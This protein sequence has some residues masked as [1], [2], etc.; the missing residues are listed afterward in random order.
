MSVSQGQLYIATASSNFY[1]EGLGNDKSVSPVGKYQLMPRSDF[2]W[3]DDEN[4][5]PYLYYIRKPSTNTTVFD[6]DH[7]AIARNQNNQNFYFYYSG[8]KIGDHSNPTEL[9]ANAVGDAIYSDIYLPT[10]WD[11]YNSEEK[12]NLLI[13]DSLYQQWVFTNGIAN[14]EY[15]IT[16]GVDVVYLDDMPEFRDNTDKSNGWEIQ[17]DDTDG[18]FQYYLSNELV[19]DLDDTTTRTSESNYIRISKERNESIFD[20]DYSQEVFVFIKKIEGAQAEEGAYSHREYDIKEFETD[21][22]QESPPVIP[23]SATR[24]PTT[25]PTVTPTISIT[26]TITE[27]PTVTPSITSTVSI[28][29]SPNA[30]PDPTK[31]PTATPSKTNSPTPSV[32]LTPAPPNT[33]I[34]KVFNVISLGS[35][36]KPPAS[37]TPTSTV[38]A[39]VTK[40]PTA[41]PT[42]TPTVTDTQTPTPTVTQTSTISV[43]PIP[44]TTP[45]ITPTITATPSPTP[46][47]P[48]ILGWNQ[49]FEIKS[50]DNDLA[51][52]EVSINESGN[53]FAV[54]YPQASGN[55]GFV[56]VHGKSET[57]IYLTGGYITGDVGP[58][59]FGTSVN[60]SA[61][62]N[63]IAI[64]ARE[65]SDIQNSN[66]KCGSVRVYEFDQNNWNQVGQTIYG[67][68]E[69]RNGNKNQVSLSKDGNILAIS[70][71]NKNNNNGAVKV[72]KKTEVS[73]NI[74]KW[75][76]YGSEISGSRLE[77]FGQNIDLNYSGNIM[78]V[79]SEDPRINSLQQ[80]RYNQEKSNVKIYEY[81]T[82]SGDWTLLGNEI[83]TP[84]DYNFIYDFPI[85]F[86]NY[87]GSTQEIE[88]YRS[89]LSN[90]MSTISLREETINDV[91]APAQP[92]GFLLV[93]SGNGFEE[94]LSRNITGS[95]S[96]ITGIIESELSSKNNID[97]EG[98][99]ESFTLRLNNFYSLGSSV[100]INDE[101]NA[102]AIGSKSSFVSGLSN[103]G[104]AEVYEY[105][106]N[107]WSQIGD[108][109][110]GSY[111][112]G[113]YGYNVKI[114][115]TGDFI[116]IASPMYGSQENLNFAR[117]GRGILETYK[118]ENN[119]W[120]QFYQTFYGRS[121]FE[122]FGFS[123]DSAMASKYQSIVVGSPFHS[124]VGY[125]SFDESYVGEAR[126]NKNKVKI[127]E[128][129]N[130]PPSVT[131]TVTNTS[132]VTPSVTVS[133]TVTPTNSTTPTTT[134][135]VTNTP[136]IT[137]TVT[138]TPTVSVTSTASVTPTITPSVCH[139]FQFVYAFTTTGSLGIQN[140][141]NDADLVA[142]GLQVPTSATGQNYMF[143]AQG[144]Y[145]GRPYYYADN[146]DYY[147]STHYTATTPN[148]GPLPPSTNPSIGFVPYTV[149]YEDAYGWVMFLDESR[150]NKPNYNAGLLINGDPYMKPN[151]PVVLTTS[152]ELTEAG[153]GLLDDWAYG[154]KADF[155]SIMGF[156]PPQCVTPTPTASITPTVTTTAS[157]TPTVTPTVSVTP[158][159]T[160]T[161]SVTPTITP[162]VSVT[163]TITTTVSIT[164][165]M[166]PSAPACLGA[167]V[168][169]PTM[170]ELND[171]YTNYYTGIITSS[172]RDSN[173]QCIYT[174]VGKGGT[175]ASIGT[176][177]TFTDI[178][179]GQPYGALM[180]GITELSFPD[181]Y[182]SGN[183]LDIS[184][185]FYPHPDNTA[186]SPDDPE[187]IS[188]D[189]MYV[190]G[191]EVNC[192]DLD[193]TVYGAAYENGAINAS[194]P[195]SWGFRELKAI[196]A[197]SNSS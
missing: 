79:G 134:P 11:L 17:I 9:Y 35:A 118:K 119:S 153:T 159:V 177:L 139:D 22:A 96:Y 85:T 196:V 143:I 18:P 83:K 178:Y 14:L 187:W 138:N 28:T 197:Y 121:T 88:Y 95:G 125:D 70:S 131:P 12:L 188:V 111:E 154:D 75:D 38:T 123:L 136:T 103:V 141:G 63:M 106:S 45:T 61:D 15:K 19:Q 7:W 145:N 144:E 59:R 181:G 51:G 97:F 34:K 80:G 41:T 137:P 112:Y 49:K 50:D 104:H 105:S 55:R 26:P 102:V 20:L 185:E 89:S 130:V 155:E 148:G 113:Q 172:S 56:S 186:A 166:T 52:Y 108:N 158:T 6:Y 90:I 135:T 183:V 16:G 164:P 81:N 68:A 24:T 168:D 53:V 132:T 107:Q 48:I 182:T 73:T 36:I 189:Y 101:G 98:D 87:T 54:G 43:T 66:I 163:P 25:T 62:G 122:R 120:Q 71:P 33:I 117:G 78:V 171:S 86:F 151:T 44:T 190:T 69:Q 94:I 1:P 37:V 149:R 60:L 193:W 72:Y 114:G 23:P 194:I 30:S 58:F 133:S 13:N 2:N 8:E 64:G 140:F 150:I 93:A 77:Y 170:Y 175:E 27:T 116:S 115:K 128:V 169:N 147:Y 3:I 46:S 167:C 129:N 110:T 124:N 10:G 47:R 195:L 174:F 4:L 179:E 40:T 100:S 31:T 29:R 91:V 126:K 160:P 146:V 84:K 109:I 57:E 191:Y 162:T 21:Q 152:Q 76:Q 99:H 165:T 67:E 32:S 156:P 92:N 176:T 42:I 173:N 74:Y 142:D 180:S 39:T 82:T 157:V 127:I 184:S 161:V 5:Y 65:D 192:G